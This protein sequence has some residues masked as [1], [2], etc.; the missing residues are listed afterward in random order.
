M[1]NVKLMLI[2]AATLGASSVVIAADHGDHTASVDAG[3]LFVTLDANKDG[4]ISK[5]EATAS[6]EITAKWDALD[7][8][9]DGSLSAK[10]LSLAELSAS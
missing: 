10:E 6:E 3:A 8:D 7:L 9:Q 5:D 4:V 1:K 2:L